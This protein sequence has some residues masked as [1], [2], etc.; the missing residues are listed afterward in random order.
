MFASAV[1]G[2]S[3]AAGTQIQ[4]YQFALRT[5]KTRNARE[6]DFEDERISDFEKARWA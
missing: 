5:A 2:D 3:E 1:K 6:G 4:L